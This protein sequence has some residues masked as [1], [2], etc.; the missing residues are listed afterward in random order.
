MD[1]W[2][3]GCIDGWMDSKKLNLKRRNFKRE[4]GKRSKMQSTTRSKGFVTRPKL[5]R[6]STLLMAAWVDSS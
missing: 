4:F 3:D 2:M 1:G 6:K 5:E